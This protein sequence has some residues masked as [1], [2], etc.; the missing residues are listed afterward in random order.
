M[1]VAL[2]DGELG[3]EAR[4]QWIDMDTASVLATLGNLTTDPY[5]KIRDITGLFD[6]PEVEDNF[7]SKTETLGAVPYPSYA[8]TKNV[9]YTV[10][11]RASSLQL[12]RRGGA[13]LRAAF[14]PDLTTGLLE[15]RA[16]IITPHPDYGSAEHV[17]K[18]RCLQLSQ[19]SDVQAHG[20]NAVPTPWRR[21]VVVGMRLYDPRIYEWDPLD[22]FG[23]TTPKW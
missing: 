9:T 14:G 10:E 18:A 23:F 22:P 7:E 2:L 21:T 8:R 1:P 11:V 17:F 5:Y 20:E 15:E 13:A 16:M 3:I 19:G 12:L 6:L 4:H